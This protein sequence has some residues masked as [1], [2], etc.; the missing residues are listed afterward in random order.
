MGQFKF[1]EV[2]KLYVNFLQKHESKIPNISYANNDKFICGI[3]FSVNDIDYYSPISS[4][5]KQQK[6]NILIKQL[7]TIK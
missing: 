7:V 6:T 3:L 5:N 1:Y 2:D 4:F